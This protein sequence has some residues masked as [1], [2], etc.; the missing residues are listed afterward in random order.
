[1]DFDAIPVIDIGALSGADIEA[2]RALAAQIGK[3]C[4]IAGFFYV[5]GHGVPAS[6]VED[7][8]AAARWFFSAPKA[9]RDA[10]DVKLSPCFRGYVPMAITGP[11]VPK[12]LLEAFQLMLDLGPDD[13][14]VKRGSVMHGP[15]RWPEDAPKFRAAL[16][17]YYS[18][19][20]GLTGRLLEAF[21]LALELPVDFFRGF[22]KKP[23]TQ[24]RLLHYPPQPPDEPSAQGVEAH[25]DTGAFTIL[26]Q[27]EVGGLEVRNRAGRWIDAKPLAGSFVINIGDMMQGW[28]NRR[29][30]STL[31]RVANRSGRDRIS[32]PFFANPDYDAIIEPIGGGGPSLAC[33]PH[34]ETAYRR[35]WP[36]AEG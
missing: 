33:G 32:V 29:F 17:A 35:A 34:V 31:H 36:R 11:G 21:A 2:K 7:V 26:L 18:D 6:D 14:D 4:E 16:D 19:M 27:D 22:F 1:M 5:T 28:T 30:V 12:R 23:L 3:A 10:L 20:T 25:T 13:A 24:L 9:V 15:N 8:F